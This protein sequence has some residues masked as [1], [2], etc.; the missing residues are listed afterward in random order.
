MEKFVGRHLE[1]LEILDGSR[2]SN[3]EL[4]AVRVKD[5]MPLL[6][7]KQLQATA[8]AGAAPTKAEHDALLADVKQV[9]ARLNEIATLLQEKLR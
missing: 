6:Q 7:F 4:A 2:N 3:R 1:R 8:A 5:L 9:V